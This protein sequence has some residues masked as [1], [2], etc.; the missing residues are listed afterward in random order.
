MLLSLCG[1]VITLFSL[2]II[3]VV[4]SGFHKFY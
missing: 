2:T 4:L 3:N 1:F